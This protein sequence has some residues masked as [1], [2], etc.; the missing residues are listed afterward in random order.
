MTD[1]NDNTVLTH[2]QNLN[3][4][5]PVQAGQI[6]GGKKTLIYFYFCRTRQRTRKDEIR[7]FF[8]HFSTDHNLEI[9]PLQKRDLDMDE[10]ESN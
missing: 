2:R 5:F 9:R 6:E 4:T 1:H 8:F 10:S 7:C 3:L